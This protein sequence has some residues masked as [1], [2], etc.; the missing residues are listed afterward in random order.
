[1]TDKQKQSTVGARMTYRAI[2]KAQLRRLNR[3][4]IKEHG[5]ALSDGFFDQ[6]RSNVRYLIWPGLPL[7]RNWSRCFV[8]WAKVPK[9]TAADFF[10]VLID[11]KLKDLE[12]FPVVQR[13]AVSA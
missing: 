3:H 1:M 13:P 11:V 12:R 2:T 7:E 8:G 5:L 9:P 6:L 10:H 4:A